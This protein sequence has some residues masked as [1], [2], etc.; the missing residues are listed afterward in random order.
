VMNQVYDWERKGATVYQMLL[1]RL[2]LEVAECIKTRMEVVRSQIGKTV[3]EKGQARAAKILSL[4]CGSAREVELFLSGASWKN[5]RAEF[6]LI[7]QEQ[8]AL[9][10]TVEKT[11]PHVLNAKGQVRV[12]CLNMSFTDILRGTGSLTSLPPQD[13]I[14]SLGLIDYLADRRAQALA[15]RLY[16]T[17]APGGMLIIG[18]MNETPLSNLWPME[19]ITDWT[20][21]YRTEPQMLAWT[22]GLEAQAAWT[23]LESTERVRLLFVRKP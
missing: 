21:Y 4:G 3:Q 23:E 6:T 20:L 12:Q 1:H 17:L 16:E 18:N 10:Y 14:Y 11:Y 2:G 19:F 9:S 8:S 5:K 7:D 15:R 22:E 13:L